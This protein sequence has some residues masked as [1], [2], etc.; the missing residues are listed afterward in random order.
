MLIRVPCSPAACRRRWRRSPRR[1]VDRTHALTI[2]SMHHALLVAV[3]ASA[4]R[5]AAAVAAAGAA[6]G[7]DESF[8]CRPVRFRPLA[9][10]CCCCRH[11]CPVSRYRRRLAVFANCS[12]H[13]RLHCRPRVCNIR[14]SAFFVG[15]SLTRFPSLFFIS[16][17]SNLSLASLSISRRPSL[18]CLL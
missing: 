10:C 16:F 3:V 11:R 14:W 1:T 8:V 12:F 13:V 9:D 15:E 6:I 5:V 18:A 2:S 7:G 4:A 17:H